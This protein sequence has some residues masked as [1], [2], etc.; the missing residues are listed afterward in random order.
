MKRLR[1]LLSMERSRFSSSVTEGFMK[2]IKSFFQRESLKM[3]FSRD[4]LYAACQ[5]NGL[6][7]DQQNRNPSRLSRMPGIPRGSQKQVLLE[8]NI[9]KSC[10]D[11]WRDW[12]EAETDELPDTENLAADWASLPPLADPLIFGV[13]RKGHKMLLAGPSKAGKSFA[14]IELVTSRASC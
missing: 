5:K 4:Y 13:L 10:W 14:L 1:K 3:W 7:I 8:T 12:L 11:H 9:G 6:T 2:P